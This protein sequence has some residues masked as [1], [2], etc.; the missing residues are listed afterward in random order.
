MPGSVKS[1]LSTTAALAV[2]LMMLPGLCPAAPSFSEAV[3]DSLFGGPTG[4]YVSD[5]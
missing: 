1:R 5:M 2:V 4:V 3:V